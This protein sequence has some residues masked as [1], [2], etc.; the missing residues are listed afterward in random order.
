MNDILTKTAARNIF[1]GGTAFFFIVFVLLVGDSFRQ[2]RMIE[3]TN[4]ISDAVA[5]GKHVWERHACF[6]CHTMYGEGARFAPELGQVWLK[7]G[8]ATDPA[9]ASAA[10]KDWF[11]AQPTQVDDRHQMPN[12]H[13][14][15]QELDN[16]I[17]FLAWTSRVNTQGW[18]PQAAK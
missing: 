15:D 16:L 5:Q 3:T 6:D 18:P 14:S 17:A 12:F 9:G 10:L 13:L 8:G 11:A 7:Y 1:F 4:P 2:A